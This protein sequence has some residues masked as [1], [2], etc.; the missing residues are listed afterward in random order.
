MAA[1]LYNGKG[2]HYWQFGTFHCYHCP[3]LPLYDFNILIEDAF[4][5]GPLQ[6]V[7]MQPSPSLP[8]PL[9]IRCL[10]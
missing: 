7:Y 2:V 3:S 6:E 5:W 10:T 1:P 8:N 9:N 4:A